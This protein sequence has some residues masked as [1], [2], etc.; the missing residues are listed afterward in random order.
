MSIYPQTAQGRIPE[1][2]TNWGADQFDDGVGACRPP[3][4][5]RAEVLSSGDAQWLEIRGELFSVRLPFVHP[6][7]Q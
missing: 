6:G 5:P 4:I 7:T 2:M 3:Q 1:T